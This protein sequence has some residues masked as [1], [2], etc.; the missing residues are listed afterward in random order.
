MLQSGSLPF[1]RA[2]SHVPF[3]RSMPSGM[4]GSSMH[5]GLLYWHIGDRIGRDVLKKERAPYG[6]R[7]LS[8][9]SK[10]LIAGYGSGYRQPSLRSL[11][12]ITCASMPP[13]RGS[14]PSEKR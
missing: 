4:S 2:L 3:L 1:S 10:E 12:A 8:T 7:I 9:V 13:C 5:V 14:S 11:S 6:K